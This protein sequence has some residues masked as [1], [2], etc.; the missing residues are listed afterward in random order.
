MPLSVLLAI[1]LGILVTEAILLQRSP[2]VRRALTHPRLFVAVLVLAVSSSAASVLVRTARA[3][4]TGTRNSYGFPKP[5]YVTW[6]S[7][8]HSITY[9]GVNWLYF[10][11]N[12][13]WWFAVLSLVTVFW[14]AR[15]AR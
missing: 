8:E 2:A 7:W 4:G 9:S 11:G 14:A 15:R 10:A 1:S 13:V 6:T 5:F 12:S 3:A